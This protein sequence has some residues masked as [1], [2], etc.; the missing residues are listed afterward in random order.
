MM[1]QYCGSV[2]ANAEKALSALEETLVS[3]NGRL[4][5]ARKKKEEPSHFLIGTHSKQMH[6]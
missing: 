5:S 6:R 3:L 2:R 4:I 1:V